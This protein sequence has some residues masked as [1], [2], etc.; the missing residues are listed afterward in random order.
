ML[1]EAKIPCRLSSGCGLLFVVW[2]QGFAV[3]EYAEGDLQQ[4]FHAGAKNHFF[5]LALRLE[6]FGQ[7]GHQRIAP[8]GGHGRQV[9]QTP[10]VAV[11]TLAD[12]RR[13]AHRCA[14]TPLMRRQARKGHYYSV[15]L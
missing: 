12:M 13:P 4:F 7:S 10:K 5:G 9:Q 1:S 2:V 3:F 6:A 11:A 14:G 15:T 8:G